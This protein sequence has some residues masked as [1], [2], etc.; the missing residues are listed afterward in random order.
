MGVCVCVCVCVCV[1]TL[2]VC[3][4]VCE[5][6]MFVYPQYLCMDVHMC[7]CV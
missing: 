5:Y 3:V 2:C 1:S 7:V 4:W 6:L